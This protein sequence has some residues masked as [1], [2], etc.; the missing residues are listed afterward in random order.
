MRKIALNG[1]DIDHAPA[2]VRRADVA[3]GEGIE[4]RFV[5]RLGKKREDGQR[6]QARHPEDDEA[7]KGEG[8]HIQQRFDGQWLK[9]KRK[10]TTL[11]MCHPERSE[12][13]LFQGL[14]DLYQRSLVAVLLRMTYYF[15]VFRE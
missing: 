5:G 10:I 7:S 9:P 2:H 4:Q 8:F 11:Q 3:P 15:E 13:P 14:L 6:E 1:L 12:G